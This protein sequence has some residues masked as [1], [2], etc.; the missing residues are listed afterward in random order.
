[1][2][3]VVRNLDEADALA[4]VVQAIRLGIECYRKVAAQVADEVV[5]RLWRIDPEKLDFAF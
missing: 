5:E 3:A 4:I 2:A 1:M